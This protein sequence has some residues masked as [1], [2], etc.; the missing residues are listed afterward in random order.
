MY[1]LYTDDLEKEVSRRPEKYVFM[2]RVDP[3]VYRAA[4]L[5][6][7]DASDELFGDGK[8]SKKVALY[9]F[10][11]LAESVVQL[12]LELVWTD[13][14]TKDFKVA[15]LLT[16]PFHYP[17]SELDFYLLDMVQCTRFE[18]ETKIFEYDIP[19]FWFGT[20]K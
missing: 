3:C 9:D 10:D 5:K 12:G 13:D 20:D 4:V 11:K 6:K 8:A 7:S 17:Q 19:G 15:A 18:T 1:N 2:E 14:P 16:H